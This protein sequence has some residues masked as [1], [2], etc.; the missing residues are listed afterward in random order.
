MLNKLSPNDHYF[1]FSRGAT[2]G[3]INLCWLALILV[4]AKP[5]PPQ[6]QLVSVRR[7]DRT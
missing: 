6:C 7:M 1:L 5:D 3:K 2:P 4:I